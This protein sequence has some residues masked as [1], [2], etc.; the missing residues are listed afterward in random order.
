MTSGWAR[1]SSFLPIVCAATAFAVLRAQQRRPAAL[2]LL[3]VAGALAVFGLTHL[4]P[5]LLLSDKG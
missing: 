4:L 2:L 3:A 5:G 1:L